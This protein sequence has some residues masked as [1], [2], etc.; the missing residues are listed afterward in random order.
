MS[1]LVRA[2]V[3]KHSDAH[4]IEAEAVAEGMQTLF[5]HGLDRVMAG[6]TTVEEVLRVTNLN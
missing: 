2:Q 6:V 3:L 1:D 5:A 4:L